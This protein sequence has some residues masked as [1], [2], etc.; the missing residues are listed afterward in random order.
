MSVFAGSRLIVDL[1]RRSWER[2]EIGADT[3]AAYLGGR[4]LGAR[5]LHEEGRHRGAPLDPATPLIVSVGTLA[6]TA[7]PAAS[8]TALTSLSPLTDTVFDANSGGWFGARLRAAGYDA[9]WIEGRSEKP[10]VLVVEAGG[11]R[12]EDGSALA[13]LG[14]R[15]ARAALRAKHGPKAALLTVGPAGER[16]AL[17]ANVAHG[18][19]FFGRGGLGASF[20][21]KNLK[22][23]VALGEGKTA[24]A[25]PEGFAFIVNECRKLLDAHPVTSKGLPQ[26]GTSVLMNVMNLTGVLPS[27]NFRAAGFDG[28][29][30]ISGE[31]LRDRLVTGRHGCPAAPSCA[32][33]D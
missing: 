22:A 28:A 31:A 21:A 3:L 16:G 33:A 15:A 17:L 27:R 11:A 9:L 20:G 6:G 8:R 10:V 2:R 25:D 26:F 19:R 5:L 29:E 1:T 12:F 13:G 7:A 14:N 4:G 23:V 24:P 32:A 30:E 18:E